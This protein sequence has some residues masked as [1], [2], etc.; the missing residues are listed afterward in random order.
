[1]KM[2]SKEVK[3]KSKVV[4]TVQVPVIE[5]I[6]ELSAMDEKKLIDLVNRQ[7]CTD[8]CNVARASHREAQPGKTKRYEVGFNVLCQMLFSD[9]ETGIQKI[10]SIQSQ[11]FD[12]RKKALDA[13]INH[14]E[15]QAE[16]TKRIG[17]PVTA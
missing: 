15:V 6:E 5:T 1:M 8:M 10:G 12:V 11:D 16:V 7:V 14:P 17:A 9:G 2:I 3:M 4:D 13:L